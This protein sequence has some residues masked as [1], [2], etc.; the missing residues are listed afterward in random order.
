MA[1]EE[2]CLANADPLF[3]LTAIK[4]ADCTHGETLP[5]DQQATPEPE[6]E[7][8]PELPCC[9]A[10]YFDGVGCDGFGCSNCCY[11]GVDDFGCAGDSGDCATNYCGYGYYLNWCN[12]NVPG[13][14]DGVCDPTC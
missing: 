3:F 1:F 12:A 11:D 10:D 2:S 6:P 14:A 8:E 13:W 7:P 5:A 4:N 9:I